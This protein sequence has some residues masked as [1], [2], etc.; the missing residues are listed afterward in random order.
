MSSKFGSTSNKI[1]RVGSGSSQ[2][3][4]VF[5]FGGHPGETLSSRSYRR[6]VLHG[7]KK[8]NAYR[9]FVDTLF[10]WEEDHCKNS[11]ELCKSFAE[12]FL[13]QAEID[14]K[15]TKSGD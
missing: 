14:E 11:Y 12:E 9:K 6:G 4:N 5:G 15:S 8:W 3:L 2:L 7:N 1:T 10:F 13:R